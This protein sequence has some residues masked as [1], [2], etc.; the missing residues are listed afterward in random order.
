MG[1]TAL[2]FPLLACWGVVPALLRVG[3]LESTEPSV[4]YGRYGFRGF[5]FVFIFFSFG[6]YFIPF[7]SILSSL[8]FSLSSLSLFW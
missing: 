6:T 3:V 7:L 8:I 1:G 5:F 2:A 4:C